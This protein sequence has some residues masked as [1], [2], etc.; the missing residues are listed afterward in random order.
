M[1]MD[2]P[3]D[4]G[5]MDSAD[6]D[7]VVDSEAALGWVDD[8]VVDAQPARARTPTSTSDVGFQDR[9]RVLLQGSMPQVAVGGST[10]AGPM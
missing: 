6:V 1:S 8:P 7:G 2:S 9:T 5:A 4:I 3:G 10:R